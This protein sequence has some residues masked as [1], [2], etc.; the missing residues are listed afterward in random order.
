MGA[1]QNNERTSR[2]NSPR[3]YKGA[4][5]GRARASEVGVGAWRDIPDNGLVAGMV[6]AL[7]KHRA[8]CLLG[9]TGDGSAAAVTLFYGDD[10]VRFYPHDPEELEELLR[11]IIA[12]AQGDNPDIEHF[13]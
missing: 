9:V 13:T 2:T 11:D 6:Y 7:A 8:G 3:A 4:V 5:G 12:W 1:N 10:R